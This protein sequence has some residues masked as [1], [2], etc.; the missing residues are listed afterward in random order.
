MTSPA[1]ALDYAPPFVPAAPP[2]SQDQRRFLAAHMQCPMQWRWHFRETLMRVTTIA[3]DV[4]SIRKFDLDDLVRAGLLVQGVGFSY[5]VTD[6]G[7][8][9]L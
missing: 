6:E 4:V 7:R 9:V 8:A 2:L 3:G 1:I 5:Q